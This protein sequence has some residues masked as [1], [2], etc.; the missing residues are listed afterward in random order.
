MAP[1]FLARSTAHRL[2][3]SPHADPVGAGDARGTSKRDKDR[4]RPLTD[5]DGCDYGFAGGITTRGMDSVSFVGSSSS[6]SC[7]GQLFSSTSSSSAGM[8]CLERDQPPC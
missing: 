6:S 4:A 5:D 1:L 2:P 7:V 3:V 8:S